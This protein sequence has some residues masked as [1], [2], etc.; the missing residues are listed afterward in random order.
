MSS[1]LKENKQCNFYKTYLQ[2]R[3]KT[4]VLM[5]ATASKAAYTIFFPVISLTLDFTSAK[6]PAPLMSTKINP[7]KPLDITNKLT[8]FDQN[9]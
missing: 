6:S 4:F 8:N 5:P 9:A 3:K 1:F 7:L 2:R